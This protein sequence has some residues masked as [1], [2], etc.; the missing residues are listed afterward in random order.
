MQTEPSW[1]RAAPFL[2]EFRSLCFSLQPKTEIYI[3]CLTAGLKHFHPPLFK[4]E[5]QSSN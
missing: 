1:I 4:Q 2:L 3:I 5:E